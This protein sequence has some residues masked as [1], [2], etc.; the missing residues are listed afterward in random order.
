MP[1]CKTDSN[2]FIK[3]K[4]MIRFSTTF[5]FVT[6]YHK[7]LAGLSARMESLNLPVSSTLIACLEISVMLLRTS[8]GPVC[9]GPLYL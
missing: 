4:K 6:G 9:P 2:I 7:A 3:L 5:D 1:G 8:W